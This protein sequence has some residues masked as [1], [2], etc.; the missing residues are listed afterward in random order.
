MV[1]D[2]GLMRRL[3][4]ENMENYMHR[5]L[6]AEDNPDISFM[7]K[8]ILGRY[9]ECEVIIVR[10]GS[11]AVRM[12]QVRLP[13]V[14][15]LDIQMPVMDGFEA[16][17]ILKNC[18]QTKHIPIVFLTATYDDLKS[19]IHGMELGADDYIIQPVDNI[20]LVTRIKVMLR[21][22]SLYDE[23]LQTGLNLKTAE[24]NKFGFL[25]QISHELRNPLNTILGFSELLAGQFHG[26]L[27]GSQIEFL[28]VVNKSGKKLLVLADDIS[29]LSKLAINERQITPES[30]SPAGLIETIWLDFQNEAFEKNISLQRQIPPETDLMV[31]DKAGIQI[32][33]RNLLQN[34]VRFNRTGGKIEIR[35][36]LYEDPDGRKGI[37][38]SVSDTGPGISPEDKDK[39][40]TPFPRI[41]TQAGETGSGLGLAICREL[42]ESM[43][44]RIEF[45]S[46]LGIGTTFTVYIPLQ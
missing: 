30:F 28:S 8:E 18:T 10:D 9:I 16:C 32:V 37:S 17:R 21:I 29:F 43:D 41:R 4:A 44:G 14:I 31:G 45:Q 7:V 24:R 40:F 25:S 42:L 19:K 35:S 23:L 12:A 34:A 46:E 2:C 22:K 27:T 11:E 33:L 39:V 5:I 6:L 1:S 20:E 36:R 13:D 26:P 38:I 15:I 3:T